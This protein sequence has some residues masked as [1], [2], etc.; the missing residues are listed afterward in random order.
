MSQYLYAIIWCH[1]AHLPSLFK[2]TIP[3]TN[4]DPRESHFKVEY[5][6][7]A[8]SRLYASW[9]DCNIISW[10]T[11]FEGSTSPDAVASCSACK[12]ACFASAPGMF[13]AMWGGSSFETGC[14]RHCFFPPKQRL[15]WQL[16]NNVQHVLQ[17]LQS[18]GFIGN[19]HE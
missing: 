17:F 4:L 12:A 11:L 10:I 15:G 8:P 2:C 9:K 7:P 19:K 3:S 6:L 1:H 13:L 16:L 5:G 18:N 14:Y